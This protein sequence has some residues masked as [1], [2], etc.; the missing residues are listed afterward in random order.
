VVEVF[1]DE[2]KEEAHNDEA[3]ML[4]K[5]SPSQDMFLRRSSEKLSSMLLQWKKNRMEIAERP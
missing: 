4:S 2:S 5:F 1:T 3:V